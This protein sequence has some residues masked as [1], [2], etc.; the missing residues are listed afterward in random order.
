M[1][2]KW[3]GTAT[4]LVKTEKTTLAID[5]Y[6]HSLN[7]AL[8]PVNAEEVKQADAVFITHPHPDHFAD[9]AAFLS[10][11]PVYVS[12][13]GIFHA[14]K[15]GIDTHTMSA[16]KAGDTH[17]IGDITLTVYQSRHC[18]FDLP[19]ILS[20]LFHP[21]TYLM[22]NKAI[23][24]LKQMREFPIG[25]DIYFF[26]IEAEGKH[27]FVMGSAGLDKATKYP[28]NADLL[29]LPYQGRSDMAKYSLPI[30]KRLNPKRVLL[31]HYDNAFPPFTRTEN[32]QKIIG[33]ARKEL[34]DLPVS[35]FVAG[36]W[37]EL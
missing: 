10:E 35:P 9:I 36:V 29:V 33:L 34:P 21:R 25:N 3:C 37:Y 5:P 27:I 30:I 16:L 17:K 26:D 32:T 1:Q 22:A 20:K 4:L 24:L 18:K 12:Q 15:K 13:N 14:A 6:L 8:P 31:D 28:K 11:A 23:M 2:I 19:L 7:T